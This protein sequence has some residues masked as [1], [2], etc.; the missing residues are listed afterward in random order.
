DG[1]GAALDVAAQ[2]DA[3]VA[4]DEVGGPEGDERD[5][6]WEG[7]LA[8]GDDLVER[9]VAADDD[10]P[11]DRR[12]VERGDVRARVP[13]AARRVDGDPRAASRERGFEPREEGGD[14]GATRGGI[15][16]DVDVHRHRAP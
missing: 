3:E 4:A 5:R 13:G 14:A 8:R 10:E 15:R 9:A 6:P 7:R 1:G 2:R 11:V 16:D 12:G